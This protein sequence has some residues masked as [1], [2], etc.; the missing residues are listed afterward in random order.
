MASQTFLNTH[1]NSYDRM[2][3][4]GT[5]SIAK[6]A[7]AML[8]IPI[9]D[10]SYVL[11]N[12]CGT[13]IVSEVIKAQCPA[14]RIMGADLAPGMLE[15]YKDK[16]RRYGWENTDT[17][18]QDV[19]NL[20]E[21]RDETFTHVITNMGFAPDA[22]DLTG[23]GRA[24]KEM[25][26]VLKPGGVAVVTT[27]YRRNFEKAFEATG[28]TIRPN[29]EPSAWKIPAE[30]NKGWWL[31]KMLDEGGFDAD[32]EVKLVKGGMQASS[33]DELVENLMYFK[34]MFFKG[35]NEEE[36][37]RLLEV[38]RKEISAAPG[39]NETNDGVKVE[40]IAWVGIAVK[41]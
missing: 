40:M 8:P 36:V 26:R 29:E 32:V 31:M 5:L 24:A 18:A 27:W 23:P 20:N 17:K 33:L 30:W 11:D 37:K 16:A 9:T 28:R 3:S 7:I 39:Y 41:I 38:M 13:G 6:Q 15:I 22:D 2:T 34:D 21:F 19:R 1:S 10:S 35:Y 14:A 4:G 12:A 25:W